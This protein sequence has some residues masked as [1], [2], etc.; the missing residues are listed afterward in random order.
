MAPEQTVSGLARLSRWFVHDALPLWADT[1][2]DSV[3]GHF[4]ECLN[5]DGSPETTGRLRTRTAARQIYVYA[6][7]SVL[8][9]APDGA[10]EQAVRAFDNLHRCAWRGPEAPGYARSFDRN[11]GA[12]IDPI[13]DLYDQACVLLALAWLNKATGE[14]R[15]R[16]HASDLLQAING[17]L[18]SDGQGWAEDETGR[19][20]RRQNPHMHLFEAM[21]ALTSATGQASD[22]ARTDALFDLFRTRFL[23]TNGMLLEYFGPHWETADAHGSDRLEPGHMAEWVWLVSQYAELRGTDLAPIGHRLL[24]HARRIGTDGKLPFLLDQVSADGTPLETT[25]RLWPQAELIKALL[26]QHDAVGDAGY[27][28]DADRVADLLFTTYLAK[29]PPG[30]WRDCFDLDGRSVARTV[31]ASSNYHL[32]TAVAA[33]IDRQGT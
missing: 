25:R 27:L 13:R 12:L 7:A 22:R 26:A 5:L 6:H 9:A 17:A 28:A 29:T 33:I 32:W 11:T 20:P 4:L 30:T 14:D 18:A 16:T 15:Y 3:N 31:P 23:D 2:F 19:L 10:L 1:G 8:K 24:D 21:I